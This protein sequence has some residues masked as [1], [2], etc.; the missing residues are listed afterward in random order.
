MSDQLP[1]L[2][3]RAAFAFDFFGTLDT[4]EDVRRIAR[5]LHGLGH[6][7]HVVSAISPGLPMDNDE[8]YAEALGA[9]GVPFTKIW[10]V[11]HDPALKTAVLRQ[12]AARAFWDDVEDYVTAARAVGISTCW[13]GKDPSNRTAVALPDGMVECLFWGMSME[14]K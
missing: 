3:G 9:L 6:E 11:D 12:I 13:V 1:I 4:H 7:V 8:A 5:W 2:S 14:S 10:R